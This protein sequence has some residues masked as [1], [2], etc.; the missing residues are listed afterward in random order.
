MEK[1]KPV[2]IP[3]PAFIPPGMLRELQRC[4]KAYVTSADSI[5][6]YGFCLKAETP[7]LVGKQYELQCG[8]H[9]ILLFYTEQKEAYAESLR[10]VREENQAKRTASVKE[11]T[12]AFWSLYKIPFRFHIEIK[13]RLTGLSLN[14]MGDGQARNTVFHLYVAED[15]TDRGLKRRNGDF[16]CSPVKSR[17]GGNWSGTLGSG[18]TTHD[19][20]GNMRMV[21]CKACLRLMERFKK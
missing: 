3:Y 10:K 17:V 16:L 9:N 11:K 2:H 13:E 14:S 15:F 7:L 19:P 18:D 5:D 20:E 8:S 6:F 12:L 4:P 1:P 21:T